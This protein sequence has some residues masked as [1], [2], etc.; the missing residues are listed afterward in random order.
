MEEY[1]HLFAVKRELRRRLQVLELQQARFGN[2]APPHIV[3]ELDDIK[4]RIELIDLQIASS[5]SATTKVNER[6]TKV[7][8]S[9][10]TQLFLLGDLGRALEL[11][12]Q[13]KEI[14]P[15]YPRIQT[16]I[17]ELK[18]EL[19]ADYIDSSGQVV[20]TELS[21]SSP[22]LREIYRSTQN[23][24]VKIV[25]LFVVFIFIFFVGLFFIYRFF[26]ESEPLQPAQT[27][28]VI[29]QGLIGTPTV[30]PT[31]TSVIT[32][33]SKGPCPGRRSIAGSELL[34]VEVPEGYVAYLMGWMFDGEVGGFL[35]TI[36]G[37]Y[38]GTHTIRTGVYCPPIP[39]NT[40]LVQDTLAQLE[41]ECKDECP[42][43]R[44]LP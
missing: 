13:I 39:T 29:S 21:T 17:R 9:R 18:R 25:A 4:K 15:T 42:T 44:T 27:P 5:K 28:S 24:I 23:N 19:E 38:T 43:R 36:N 31:I 20:N 34:Q 41:K 16:I 7:L 1:E 6:D 14:D 26:Q 40:N 11:Y 33:T 10:A 30:I 3:L 35:V 37:P 32:P 8:F 2:D 12:L 22:A